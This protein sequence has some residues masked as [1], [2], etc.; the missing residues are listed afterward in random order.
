MAKLTLKRLVVDVVLE[1][2]LVAVELEADRR[3]VVVVGSAGQLGGEL[4]LERA[5]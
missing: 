4:G 3:R 5:L 1:L 2:L